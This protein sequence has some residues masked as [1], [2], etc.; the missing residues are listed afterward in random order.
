M[1]EWDLGKNDKEKEKDR[2]RR[3]E[4]RPLDKRRHRSGEIS[5]EPGIYYIFINK[6]RLSFIY[7]FW[8]VLNGL[9][10]R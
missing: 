6:V 4:T 10:L 2:L 7:M 1:R 5:P 9:N 3:D 8:F